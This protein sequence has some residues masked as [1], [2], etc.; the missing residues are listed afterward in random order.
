MRV[1]MLGVAFAVAQAAG[2]DLTVKVVDPTGA[3]V[4]GA[5]V[6]LRDGAGEVLE[7]KI[8]S[9]SGEARFTASGSTVEVTAQEFAVAT[10]AVGGRS[11]VTVE[12]EVAAVRSRVEIELAGPESVALVAAQASEPDR[13]PQ[14]DLVESLRGTPH[15]HLLRRGGINFEP[16]VQ[17]LRETQ[18]AMLVD[19]TRTFAAGPARMDSELSHV[20]PADVQSV[21]VVTGPYALTEGAGAMGAILVRSA[22]IPRQQDWRLGG[23][24]SLGWRSNGSGRVGR[25]RLDLGN[26]AFGLSL[27]AGGD[28]LGDY[29]A[30]ASGRPEAAQIPGGASAH[31]LGGKLRLN[32]SDRQELSLGGFYDEQ[33][34]VDYP[35]RLLTAEHF[36][37]R[38]WQAGYS[39][40]NPDGAVTLLRFNTYLNKKSHRMSNRGKPTAQAMP[41]RM[42]PFA[43][44]VSLPTEADTVGAAGRIELAPA[45]SWRVRTGFDAFRLEQAAQRFIARARDRRL[46]F[47]DAVWADVSLRNIGVYA[48]AGRSFP[49]GEL[50][51]ALRFDFVGSDAGRPTEFFLEQAG[52]ELAR[53]ETNANFSA[54][55]RYVLGRGMSLSGGF[56]RVVRTANALE[57]YS[58]RFP[59]TRFQVAAEFMGNPGIL[60][61]ASLQGDLNLEWRVADF[62]F[63]AGGYVRN[64]AN[65]IT[66]VPDPSLPKRLPLSPP[67]V[68]RY[69]NGEGAL[70]R[71]LEP[72]REPDG[73]VRRGARAGVEDAGRRSGTAP[74]R[75]RY[76]AA[77]KSIPPSG[78]CLG[79][80]ASGRST[81]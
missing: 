8:G 5:T 2:A 71:G 76:C 53:A 45:T 16:V 52:A 44:D 11:S 40:A 1:L 77:R 75:P 6:V 25:T 72:R 12:L 26:A 69:I 56:G 38:S 58:D 41:G 15:V 37:L 13:L 23:R 31:Q 35:G 21:V 55:G 19:G 54:A 74:T 63:H 65:Y 80:D 20:D 51:A 17:G 29:R 62:R 24:A 50:Q 61:E 33:T 3:V 10:V 64:L 60:P 7:R 32:P 73:Q 22:S 57:R 9:G 14:P 42:P 34:G 18:V 81:A 68:F 43:L 49:R 27:R 67:T 46:L 30:G 79:L 78:S 4:P 66:V 39:R 59:S 70:F 36:L 48:E 47:S 28:L